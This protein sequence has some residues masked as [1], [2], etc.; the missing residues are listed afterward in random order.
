MRILPVPSDN[1]V[2]HL[3]SEQVNHSE[4]FL[5]NID[6][7]ETLLR[8]IFLAPPSPLCMSWAYREAGNAKCKEYQGEKERH[9]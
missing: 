1:Q 8:Y 7:T 5:G 4:I 2:E 9:H 3:S 6:E